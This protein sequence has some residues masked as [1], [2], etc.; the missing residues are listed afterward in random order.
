MIKKYK[1]MIIKII[2][3]FVFALFTH[4]PSFAYPLTKSLKYEKDT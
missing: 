3:H 4:K 1:N 2:A